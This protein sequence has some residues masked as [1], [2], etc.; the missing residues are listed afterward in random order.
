MTSN[1]GHITCRNESCRE[2]HFSVVSFC[3]YCG[4][5]QAEA[6]IAPVPPDSALPPEP[7]LLE[8]VPPETA[9]LELVEPELAEPELVEP[10]LAK[11]EPVKPE[12][13]KPELVEPVPVAPLSRSSGVSLQRIAIGL[14]LASVLVLGAWGMWPVENNEVPEN[15]AI[16]EGPPAGNAGTGA[17]QAK[18]SDT[19]AA[20]AKAKA[21]AARQK[22]AAAKAEDDR[23]KAEAAETKARADAEKL[24]AEQDRLNSLR[25]AEAVRKAE[26]AAEAKKREIAAKVE[27][28]LVDAELWI[29][30][31]NELTQAAAIYNA[32]EV[33]SSKYEGVLSVQQ[34]RRALYIKDRWAAIRKAV[35]NDS[36]Q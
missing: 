2:V 29:T 23:L 16:S 25:D 31:E 21:E 3:P 9:Q 20:K 22:A 26:A 5:R 33:L 10:E 15:I 7:A 36:V 6:L 19:E 27:K 1:L 24:R 30:Q 28:L 4:E 12:P 13:V 35:S 14:S 18:T 8:V 34:T 11:P 17:N 32:N